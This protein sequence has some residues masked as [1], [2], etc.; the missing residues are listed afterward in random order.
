MTTTPYLPQDSMALTMD[1]TKR[2]PDAK[3]LEKFGIRRCQ[4]TPAA[5]K[6]ILAEVTEAV[7]S[8]LPTLKQFSELDTQAGETPERMRLAWIEGLA[9]LA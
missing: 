6:A 5:A 7:A 1:G 8:A 3:R 9:S 2:W 4:L